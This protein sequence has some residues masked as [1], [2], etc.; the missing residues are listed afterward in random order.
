MKIT[1]SPHRENLR[2]KWWGGGKGQRRVRKKESEKKKLKGKRKGSTNDLAIFAED[3]WL[4]KKREQF[5]I[6]KKNE[7]G[8][9]NPKRRKNAKNNPGLIDKLAWSKKGKKKEEEGQRCTDLLTHRQTV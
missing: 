5:K 1:L 4:E 9:I 2:A 3:Q 8:P 6:A 7:I